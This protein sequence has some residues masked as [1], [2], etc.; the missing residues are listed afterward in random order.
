MGIQILRELLG[1]GK[2]GTVLDAFDPSLGSVG[3]YT[4]KDVSCLRSVQA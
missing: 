2:L 4:C 3:T 1:T